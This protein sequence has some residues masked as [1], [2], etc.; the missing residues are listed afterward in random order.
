MPRYILASILQSHGIYVWL[1]AIQKFRNA[2]GVRGSTIVL[3]VVTFILGGGAIYKQS[4]KGRHKIWKFEEHF[5]LSLV[6]YKIIR[7]NS[8]DKSSPITLLKNLS[9]LK[10][11]DVACMWRKPPTSMFRG[12]RCHELFG[13]KWLSQKTC[14][15]MQKI[16]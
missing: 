6:R 16:E 15:V 5:L 7:M 2:R 11:N 8:M 10:V 3:H 12:S 14:C 4:R 1:G 13:E 9:D